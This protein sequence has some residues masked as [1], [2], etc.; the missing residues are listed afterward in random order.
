MDLS[1]F[2][3]GVRKV[4]VE[5]PGGLSGGAMKLKLGVGRDHGKSADGKG[6]RLAQEKKFYTH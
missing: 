4:E 2:S 1:T 6:R 5:I 3:I